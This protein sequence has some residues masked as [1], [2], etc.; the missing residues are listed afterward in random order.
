M[1]LEV[2][3]NP[4]GVAFEGKSR[5]KEKIK[6]PQIRVLREIYSYNSFIFFSVFNI[7]SPILPVAIGTLVEP[8]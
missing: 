3:I 4:L 5:I 1:V 6:F 7:I 2:Y 8:R